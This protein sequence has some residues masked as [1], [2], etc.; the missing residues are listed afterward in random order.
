MNNKFVVHS[1]SSLDWWHIGGMRYC[2][3]EKKING[4]N[5]FLND[6]LWNIGLVSRKQ[7]DVKK[8]IR[9]RE[10]KT[11]SDQECNI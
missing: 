4:T 6:S 8:T 3:L 11:K 9:I 2:W 1:K 5:I 7:D 10:H